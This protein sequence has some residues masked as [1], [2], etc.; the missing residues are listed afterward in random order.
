MNNYFKWW[1]CSDSRNTQT[2]FKH[3]YTTTHNNKKKKRVNELLEPIS[4][5][6]CRVDPVRVAS[7]IQRLENVCLRGKKQFLKIKHLA[8]YKVCPRRTFTNK[9]AFIS[10]LRWSTENRPEAVN[11]WWNLKIDFLKHSR[12]IYLFI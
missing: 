7:L 1:S 9:S 6:V 3:H 4:S 12:I 2:Q 11:C 8:F 5:T 10:D